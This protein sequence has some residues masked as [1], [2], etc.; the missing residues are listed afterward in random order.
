MNAMKRLEA[1]EHQ[2]TTPQDTNG[3]QRT[4][5]QESMWSNLLPPFFT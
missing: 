1:E 5:H 2:I 3:D 4:Q